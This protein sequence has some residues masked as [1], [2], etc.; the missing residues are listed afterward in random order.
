MHISAQLLYPNSV[1]KLCIF[2]HRKL[3]YRS[4]IYFVRKLL[5]LK[6]KLVT[7]VKIRVFRTCCCI[8][9]C[10]LSWMN[11]RFKKSVACNKRGDKKGCSASSERYIPEVLCIAD[12][13]WVKDSTLFR[14][15]LTANFSLKDNTIEVSGLKW[16][17]KIF[18]IAIKW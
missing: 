1:L 3:S 11:L 13:A 5:H 8:S 4:M 7:R 17:Y 6:W 12:N 10:F 9:G 15:E 16:L 2:F 14:A 18:C